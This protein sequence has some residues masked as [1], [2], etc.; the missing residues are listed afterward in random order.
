MGARAAREAIARAGCTIEEIDMIVC[1]TITPD[2][3]TPSVACI[4]QGELEAK[5]AF[6]LD[7]S[8]A[9]SGFVNALDIAEKY[10]ASGEV[11][12][13][14][15]ISAE[16]LSHI[17][18]FEDR[19][20]CVLF[21]DGAGAC[22]VTK[23]DGR[24]ASYLGADGTGASYLYA[25]AHYPQTPFETEEAILRQKAFDYLDDGFIHMNGK[26]VYKFSTSVMPLAI[27]QACRKIKIEPQDISL[28][29]PHQANV[30]IIRTGMKNLGLPIEKAYVN[31]DKTGNTS[32]AS[33]PIALDEACRENRIHRGDII[34]VVGFGAGLTFAA[35]VFDW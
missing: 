21:G 3:H 32:S 14:L 11:K 34:A 1:S 12:T 6:C 8:C 26:E 22:V 2:C 31:I 19:S 10:I 29:I 5:N 20:T 23:G 17:A 27:Q 24:Y 28:I 35:A 9:C 15:V 7:V 18:N 16:T 30:R 25:S 13:A 4:I 33:I